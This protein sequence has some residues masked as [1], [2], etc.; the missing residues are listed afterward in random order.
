MGWV[1]V[2]RKTTLSMDLELIFTL[3]NIHFSRMC[4]KCTYIKSNSMCASVHTLSPI[5]TQES[6][7]TVNGPVSIILP[8]LSG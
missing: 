3:E 7:Q 8:E 6:S 5:S 2:S 4:R 1:H